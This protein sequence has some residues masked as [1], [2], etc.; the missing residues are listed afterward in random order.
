MAEDLVAEDLVGRVAEVDAVRDAARCAVAGRG[1]FVLFTG[2]PGIGRTRLLD[3][4]DEV[5]AA[6][7]LRVLRGAGAPLHHGLSL[8]TLAG[9]YETTPACRRMVAAVV[10][11][12]AD[13]FGLLAAATA[14]FD[15]WCQLGPVAVLLD[16]L[17]HADDDSLRV[18]H[19]L[20]GR[21]A[22]SP[23]L[24]VA[25][26]RTGHARLAPVLDGAGA[27][28]LGGLEPEYVEAL[29]RACSTQSPSTTAVPMTAVEAVAD[30]G[31][32]PRYLL[33]ATSGDLPA[34]ALRLV[35][36]LPDAGAALLRTVALLGAGSEV[37]ELA[38]ALGRTEAEVLRW[39]TELMAQELLAPHG[40]GLAVVPELLA[41]GLREV[42]GPLFGQLNALSLSAGPAGPAR[43]G[44]LLDRDPA[45]L[46]APARRWIVRHARLL[47]AADPE[48]AVRLLTRSPVQPAHTLDEATS[49]RA[50]LADAL[51][52]SGRTEE[53]ERE[54]RSALRVREAAELRIT[55]AMARVTVADAEGA[56]AV[57][58]PRLAYDERLLG[59]AALCRT[60]AGDLSG[61]ADL[62][63]RAAD[64]DDPR[65][66][67]HALHARAVHSYLERDE[68]AAV[69]ELAQARDLLERELSDPGLTV[70][71][72]LLRLVC[73]DAE[74]DALALVEEAEPL[75]RRLGGL[76][77]SWFEMEAALVTANSGQWN[78]ARARLETALERP[79]LYGMAR[80]LYGLAAQLGL[81]QGDLES[82]RRQT[83]AADAARATLR[84]VAVFYEGIPA[85]TDALLAEA[86]GRT[87]EALTL[88][89][90]LLGDGRDPL[91]RH[92]V[93]AVAAALV[94]LCLSAGD[95][96]LAGVLIRTARENA[97]VATEAER[98]TVAYCQAL[99]DENPDEL[100][101]AQAQLLASGLHLTA[102]W[103]G[104]DAARLLAEQ[105]R[106]DEARAPFTAALDGYTLLAASGEL[107]RA[108]A[109]LRTEGLRTG[110][111]GPRGR[112]VSG[113]DSLTPTQR[114]VAE[115]VAQ[116][117][118]NPETARRL[119]V[120]P[121]TV[122]THVSQILRKLG[123]SSRVGIAVEVARRRD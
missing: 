44:G 41:V 34:C 1:G 74:A 13:G 108:S 18:L 77:L 62:I 10:E 60:M 7:G 54:A 14:L 95:R 56:L 52:W 87:A 42:Y 88:I 98:A 35:R 116:G 45:P 117:C 71:N 94:R 59:P 102:A 97:A 106:I 6:E 72:R 36:Q 25:T 119:F 49:V 30:S 83:A 90:G 113:W 15:T 48:V 24:L 75:A 123:L 112:P 2:P 43:I 11:P 31:G 22:A 57:L 67:A 20:L 40:R 85:L 9:T 101:A 100:R 107:R 110:V 82:F 91:P 99:L 68:P 51:L 92:S 46:G 118:T 4:L 69:R 81:R 53:A 114:R 111:K 78:R 80:P 104:E 5:V 55:V 50:A 93:P 96:D 29:G 3:A 86:D 38:A 122:Q 19:L 17:H 16:D 66:L 79:E 12:I 21:F 37:D 63:A 70:L 115:L 32:N 64:S 8:A 33:A 27:R 76:W 58:E 103:A 84:G 89:R 61:A 26:A 28:T 105:G 65:T 23:V 109:A 121:R 73:S 120:S 47:A 39:A